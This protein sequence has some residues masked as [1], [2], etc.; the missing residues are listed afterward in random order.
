M[1]S[2]APTAASG[3]AAAAAPDANGYL[4]GLTWKE[5]E[6]FFPGVGKIAYEGPSSLNALAFKHYNAEEVVMGKT[7]EQWCRFG[8]CF[9]HTFRGKG[10]DPFGAPTMRRPWDDEAHNLLGF[11]YRKLGDF[12][13]ALEHYQEAL[14][15]NPHHRGALE[16]LGEAYL[17]MN[18]LDQAKD[19]LARLGIEC[20]RVFGAQSGWQAQCN[21]WLELK[22]AI[23][24]YRK[25]AAD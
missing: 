6:E 3:D 5:G 2:F 8:V 23:E 19:T 20:Q 13:R 16:Y 21:E 25:K 12:N 15:L 17:E 11:S 4:P 22:E 10:A 18:R 24:D 9:W 14:D 1:S 7:M